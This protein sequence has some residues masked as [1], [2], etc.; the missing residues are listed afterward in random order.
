[1]PVARS[2]SWL[3][4]TVRQHM[5]NPPPIAAKNEWS[6]ALAC[7]AWHLT[8]LGAFH[9][10]DDLLQRHGVYY[11]DWIH[12]PGLLS[13]GDMLSLLARA[14]LSYRQFYHLRKK[15]E[16]LQ[17]ISTNIADYLA[18]FAITRTPTNH[19][20]AIDTWNGDVVN[21]MN[22]DPQAPKSISFKWDDLF[23]AHD[24]DVLWIFK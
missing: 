3:T 4:L 11:P 1:M 14:G 18:G 23:A 6:C 12:R 24:A 8:R 9:T 22:P 17:V 20:M 13:R 19:C 10:Q 21:L 7:I 16:V 15:D 5:A 2:S